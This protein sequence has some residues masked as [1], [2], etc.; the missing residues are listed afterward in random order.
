MIRTIAATILAPIMKVTGFRFSKDY[1]HGVTKYHAFVYRF[2][3]TIG[4]NMKAGI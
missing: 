4:A 1:R 3:D 2:V